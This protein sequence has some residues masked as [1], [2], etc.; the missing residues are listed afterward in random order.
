MGERNVFQWQTDGTMQLEQA[1]HGAQDGHGKEFWCVQN[2]CGKWQSQ[3]EE[4][5]YGCGDGKTDMNL[6]VDGQISLELI[7]AYTGEA[8]KIVCGIGTENDSQIVHDERITC[9]VKANL[10][11]GCNDAVQDGGGDGTHDGGNGIGNAKLEQWDTPFPYLL[12]EWGDLIGINLSTEIEVK[13]R[14]YSK[15]DG[16][17]W[18]DA[19]ETK[20]QIYYCG[21]KNSGNGSDKFNGGNT[22]EFVCALEYSTFANGDGNKKCCWGEHKY[23]SMWMVVLEKNISSIEEDSNAC[24]EVEKGHGERP[25]AD[26]LGHE[27]YFC[28]LGVGVYFTE[29]LDAGGLESDIGA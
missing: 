22:F 26:D 14:F 28:F 3:D 27:G 10:F 17:A 5:D 2:V 19:L 20:G 4:H 21:G 8:G 12:G 7:V 25:G 6:L 24:N 29:L 15:A 23:F 11:G 16:D 18:D 13:D 9:F 1:C